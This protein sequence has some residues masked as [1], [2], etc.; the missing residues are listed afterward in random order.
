[1]SFR[2]LHIEDNDLQIVLVEKLL[3][4]KLKEEDYV[5][6]P[7]R[8]LEEAKRSMEE[9]CTDVVL[10]DLMLPDSTGVDS[11]KAVKTAC[12]NVPIIVLTGTDDVD[13]AKATIHAGASTYVRKSDIAALPLIIILTVEKWEMEKELNDRC[14]LYDSVVNLSPDYICRFR[15]NG[16]ITFVNRSFAALALSTEEV[17]IGTRIC[18]YL[19]EKTQAQL[20]GVGTT[21]ANICEIADGG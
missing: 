7:C 8:S 12:P 13:V 5:Y 6:K 10:V 11:V 21:L 20:R 3:A 14:Q 19:D 4:K 17:M 15:P 18:D 2:I 16:M 1:M 9:G